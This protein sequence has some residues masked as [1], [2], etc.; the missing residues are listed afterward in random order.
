MV[1]K[2]INQ[3]KPM[4]LCCWGECFGNK[5]VAVPYAVFKQFERYLKNTH[6]CEIQ[7]W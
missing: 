4:E 1:I 5:N 7:R 3:A 6:S 2:E